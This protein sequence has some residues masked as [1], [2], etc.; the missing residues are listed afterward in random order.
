MKNTESFLE[1]VEGKKTENMTSALL[2]YF[3]DRDRE[4][5]KEFLQ[6]ID[7]E[8]KIGDDTDITIETEVP[9]DKQNEDDPN[10]RIDLQISF[11]DVLIFIENKIWADFQPN[12]LER[13]A[14]KLSKE[15]ANKPYLVLICPKDRETE[16]NEKIQEILNLCSSGEN[17][18]IYNKITTQLIFWNDLKDILKRYNK[19]CLMAEYLLFLNICLWEDYSQFKPEIMNSKIINSRDIEYNIKRSFL[20]ITRNM[21]KNKCPEKTYFSSIKPGKNYE[22]TGEYIGFY[23]KN[24]K[25]W[26]GFCDYEGEAIFC[27]TVPQEC[28]DNQLLD[29]IDRKKDAPLT[30]KIKD[31]RI[32]KSRDDHRDI[33]RKICECFEL[34]KA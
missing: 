27:I 14:K 25:Y 30:Y 9:Y 3:F 18:R 15:E 22:G 19:S 6:R 32:F 21:M 31:K 29:K 12:Q 10:S 34:I 7:N 33:V 23:F 5:L 2:K 1:C 16:A 4:L 17:Q 8:L 20:S 11:D 28:R 26:I 24:K 13:Y